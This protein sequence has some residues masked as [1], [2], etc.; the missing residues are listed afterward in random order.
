MNILGYAKRIKDISFNEQPFND[1]DALL[2]ADLAYMNFVSAIKDEEFRLLK[3]IVVENNKE[4][5]SVSYDGPYNKKLM[6]VIQNSN[7]YGDVKIGFC[8]SIDDVDTQTQ[9]SAITIIL[10]NGDGYV[11]YRGTDVTLNG[12]KE[13]LIVAYQDNIPG[14]IAALDYLSKAVTMFPGSFYIGGHSKGGNLALYSALNMDGKLNDRFIKIYSFDGPGFGKK[15]SEFPNFE[16]V[17]PKVNKYITKNDMI[18]VVYNQI[19]NAKIIH[20]TGIMFGGHDL[21]KWQIDYNN[22]DFKYNEDRS[23]IS[24]SHEEALMNWLVNIPPSDKQLAVDVLCEFMGESTTVLD[25]L[26]NSARNLSNGKANLDS[27]S[28]EQ[29]QRAKEIFK[30][31]AVYYLHAYSPKAIFSR[32]KD[33]KEKEELLLENGD[34][35]D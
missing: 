20:S 24:K 33:E 4:F 34:E 26:M 30:K 32:N 6:S 1:V 29:R 10:P 3:E 35:K 28:I 14:A 19:E 17:L 25:W 23:F 8:V 27:Y 7:R 22:F 2:F 9:F 5:Y 13:D 16:C 15:L 11:S 31:L 12:I 21:Y 18:G